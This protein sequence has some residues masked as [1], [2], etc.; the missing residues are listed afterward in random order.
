MGTSSH[1]R[2]EEGRRRR[3]RPSHR[4]LQSPRASSQS[5]AVD[6]TQD[7]GSPIAGKVWQRT[8]AAAAAITAV[9]ARLGGLALEARTLRREDVGAAARA[10]P[11]AGA[12][13][14][15]AVAAA[16]AAVAAAS[17][18][19]AAV[20]AA[21]ETAGGAACPRSSHT[22]RRQAHR[23]T[24]GSARAGKGDAHRSRRPRRRRP[25]RPA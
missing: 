7:K 3:C 11:V 14:R 13:R 22:V 5:E 10:G 15:A 23:R 9:V 18:A 4:R 25:G 17:V 24:E 6:N 19:A 1:R 8:S 2:E 21:A 12:R 16:A 20:A